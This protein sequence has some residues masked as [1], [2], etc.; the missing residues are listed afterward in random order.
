MVLSKLASCATGLIG[1][2]NQPLLEDGHRMLR[3]PRVLSVFLARCERS[4]PYSASELE[5]GPADLPILDGLR[6]R[7]FLS[8]ALAE[9][10]S[11]VLFSSRSVCKPRQHMVSACV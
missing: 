6:H 10:R 5:T 2:S 11:Q 4:S 8:R 3:G 1:L 7:L 9:D